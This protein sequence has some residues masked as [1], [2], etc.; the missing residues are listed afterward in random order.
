VTLTEFLFRALSPVFMVA[1]ALAG[2]MIGTE[3]GGDDDD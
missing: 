3:R 1:A 2:G